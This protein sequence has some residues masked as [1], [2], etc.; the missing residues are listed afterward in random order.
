ME[1]MDENIASSWGCI[2]WLHSV[3]SPYL[4]RYKHKISVANDST[5]PC[6]SHTKNCYPCCS[7]SAGRSSSLHFLHEHCQHGKQRYLCCARSSCTGSSSCYSGYN[8]FW[9][10]SA[11]RFVLF[12][13]IY[14]TFCCYWL[15]LLLVP[16]VTSKSTISFLLLLLGALSDYQMRDS[17]GKGL[18]RH[19]NNRY[20]DIKFL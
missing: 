20:N 1:R 16:V 18:V 7:S 6:R 3:L 2:W 4:L 10:G 12:Y 13:N 15:D 11:S 8:P 14:G 17:L 19:V 9:K 5:T